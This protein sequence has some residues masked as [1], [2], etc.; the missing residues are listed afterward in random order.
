[1]SLAALRAPEGQGDV[2]AVPAWS[3]AGLAVEA[4]Q[5]LFRD[6]AAQL[7]DVSLSDARRLALAEAEQLARE[8]LAEQGLDATGVNS[9]GLIV[10]GHQPELF[11]PGVWVKNFAACSLAQQ[12]GLVSLNLIVDN[13]T[14][15]SAAVRVPTRV[16]GKWRVV[17]VPCDAPAPAQPWEEREV[18]DEELFRRFAEE[19]ASLT[20]DW[21][22]QPVVGELWKLVRHG[23]RL[24]ERLAM[25]RHRLE[26]KWGCS[27]LELPLSQLCSSAAFARF[28]LAILLELPRFWAC[29]NEELARFRKLRRVRSNGR[30]VP[31]LGRDGEWLEAPFWV[32]RGGAKAR[33]KLYARQKGDALHL[34]AGVEPM[35]SLRLGRAGPQLI[36][37]FQDLAAQGWKVRTRALTTTLFARL[38]LADLFIHGI[39]GAIYDQVT[40]GIMNSFFRIRPP[41]FLTLSA[42][43]R[44]PLSQCNRRAAEGHL[45]ALRG[46]L[47][48]LRY[49]PEKWLSPSSDPVVL[50]ALDEKRQLLGQNPQEPGEKR[51][52]WRGLQA[53]NEF[54][55]GRLA[56]E[57]RTL[58][59]QLQMAEASLAE[60]AMLQSRE[61]AFCLHEESALRGLMRKVS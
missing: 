20:A 38:C 49:K 7:L 44:L 12:H 9:A 6:S 52:R 29:H 33:G 59:R 37:E 56:D 54:L 35:G 32:W 28:V 46:K 18:L 53:L 2:L 24:G 11:H 36:D 42:T 41:Q 10:T 51:E 13:D 17:E 27:N 58:E 8:F 14:A 47:R 19:V 60:C 50:K 40:D 57:R 43:L 61:F 39:G 15:R 23:P 31:D 16:E 3:E 45:L 1:M 55:S 25:G 22:A 4:N 5:R 26:R 34:R 21:P 48:D 30:P